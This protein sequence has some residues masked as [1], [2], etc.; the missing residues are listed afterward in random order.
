MTIGSRFSAIPFAALFPF[1]LFAP[2]S[3]AAQATPVGPVNPTNGQP[4]ATKVAR[5]EL[6][7]PGAGEFLLKGTLPLPPDTWSADDAPPFYIFDEYAQEYH[8]AQVE[9]ASRYSNDDSEYAD[10]IEVL[11]RVER[12]PETPVGQMIGYDVLMGVGTG[13]K[14]DP[15]DTLTDLTSL[16]TNL[17]PQVG[18]LL[19]DPRHI[20]VRAV[21]AYGETFVALPLL[22]SGEQVQTHR[23]GPKASTVRFHALMNKIGPPLSDGDGDGQE[24]AVSY[25]NLFGVHLYVTTFSDE[26]S[27]LID[28]RLN[29]GLVDFDP[30]NGQEDLIGR[31]Y[32]DSV[33]LMIAGSDPS[34]WRLQTQHYTGF[35]A[36]PLVAPPIENFLG[37][38]PPFLVFP[39]VRPLDDPTLDPKVA[40]PGRFHMMPYRAQ[41]VRRMALTPSDPDGLQK[42]HDLLHRAGQAF[43]IRG[44]S[45]TDLWSWWNPLTARYFPQARPFPSLPSTGG[46]SEASIRQTLENWFS[47]IQ[48]GVATQEPIV[49][50]AFDNSTGSSKSLGWARPLGNT[51]GG[52]SGGPGIFFTNGVMTAAS[53]SNAGYRL[54]EVV[55][56]LKSDRQFNAS[57]RADGMPTRHQDWVV[58]GPY[59]TVDYNSASSNTL[60][61]FGNPATAGPWLSNRLVD[62]QNLHPRYDL[63]FWSH[64]VSPC[65]IL[66]ADILDCY[67]H[68]KV[69]HTTRYTSF[70]L[71][72]A[73]L[74]N[75]A[76][77]G[78]DVLL[79]AEVERFNY[80]ELSSPTME[81][82]SG[83]L[84][85]D[86][87]YIDGQLNS[88]FTIDRNEGWTIWLN[89]AA[90]R[91]RNPQY[92]PNGF[93][94]L[95][96]RED[97]IANIS[98]IYE[99]GLGELRD[100]SFDLDFPSMTRVGG[101]L[102]SWVFDSGCTCVDSCF[103]DSS[104]AQP[105]E[106]R[107]RQVFQDIIVLHA[108][109]AATASIPMDATVRGRMD[110]I[111]EKVS[112]ST[113]M[114]Y[115]WQPIPGSDWAPASLRASAPANNPSQLYD[116]PT[117]TMTSGGSL[118]PGAH[119]FCDGGNYGMNAVH[120]L[121]AAILS[122][123]E[124]T[125][126]PVFL[127]RYLETLIDDNV[128][129]VVT[130]LPTSSHYL[131]DLKA[132]IVNQAFMTYDPTD[133][134]DHYFW[135][136]MTDLL[137]FID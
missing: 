97:W 62:Q 93:N 121:P 80:T 23:Y 27:V 118:D 90:A 129:T 32:F 95:Q 131:D 29:N 68:T 38:G 119:P 64:Q 83:S 10:V 35:E 113:I 89:A 2:V 36:D 47:A 33:D 96:D 60:N 107:E 100:T 127:E 42:G 92:D 110:A 19:S 98:E 3:H 69:T 7:S 114:P 91:I 82:F 126:D 105:V 5:L 78:D 58:P 67:S 99:D 132:E 54:L 52:G 101:I 41:T 22:A 46:S 53:R 79:Q 88:G 116:L 73:Y 104:E 75:D 13:N 84:Y 70:A 85:D 108:L 43:C 137:G 125:G 28:L 63:T 66:G 15:T 76:L 26:R 120:Y 11:A 40:D 34:T 123:Y 136:S 21:D 117:D 25:P 18:A 72:L 12:D 57:Y 6:E 9:L 51:N 102:M 48:V 124:L 74:G 59:I 50:Q 49:G 134:A 1:A 87:L 55:H 128:A 94:F 56:Q 8:L 39:L 16:I 77:A 37:A 109:H 133:S 111:I 44:S 135:A 45:D 30:S 61:S 31:V 130:T 122:G 115:S 71:A 17:D 86:E 112:Y 24:T 103:T 106:T 65:Q 14:P 4:V 81:A 20:M